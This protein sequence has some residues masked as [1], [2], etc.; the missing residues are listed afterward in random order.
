MTET[1]STSFGW[2]IVG[3]AA[4]VFENEGCPIKVQFAEEITCPEKGLVEIISP[5]DIRRLIPQFLPKLM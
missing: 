4:P 5:E 2:K 1:Y 3:M